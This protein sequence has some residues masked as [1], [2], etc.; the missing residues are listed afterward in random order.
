MAGRIAYYG[1]IVTNGLILD[2]DAAKRDSYPGTGT[3]W[4]DISG[5]QN[6]GTLVNGPTY[7]SA[8]GGSLVF[9]GSNDYVN[10]GNIFNEVFAGTSKKFTISSWVK[11]NSLQR[12]T[13]LAKLGD[14]SF[15]ENQRQFYFGI[16]SYGSY[17]LV[18]L[19]FFS[20]VGGGYREYRTVGANIQTN[21]FYN[22][23]ISYDG[24]FADANRFGLY[25]NGASYSVT[26]T[27]SLGSWG[28][29]QSGTAR[30]SIGAYVGTS[31]SS[32]I[33]LLNGNIAQVSIYNRALSAAEVSQNYNALR[34][35]YGI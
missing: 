13:I 9:D 32:P 25:V 24:S 20:L 21:T 18:F 26:P 30:L 15:G 22:L 4:N 28:D 14:S 34:G 29:I 16:G 12:I 3:T 23:V 33:G 1:G 19:A 35:R 17:E 11:F 10:L 8:N 27:Q 7:N 31:S 5:N 6:N 2:L